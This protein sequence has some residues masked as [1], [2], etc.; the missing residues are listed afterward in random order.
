MRARVFVII[1]LLALSTAAVAQVQT[2][3]WN[4][5]FRNQ[6]TSGLLEDDLDL[7]LG[8][9]GYL[10]PARMTLIDGRRLYTNLANIFTSEEEQFGAIEAQTYVIG[11]TS[12]ILGYG[13][14]GL[15]YSQNTHKVRDSSATEDV[16]LVDIDPVTNP[17]YD[18]RYVN[19]YQDQYQ[20]T[21]GA[22]YYFLGW[23]KQVN[24]MKLGIA[25]KR[26]QNS[27]MYDYFSNS[28]ITDQNI[29]TGQTTY[30]ETIED[31]TS[32]G[33]NRNLNYV[34]ASAWKPLN[35]K[36]DVSLRLAIGFGSVKNIT[37]RD[38]SRD[39]SHSGDDSYN[40]TVDYNYDREYSG[41]A[42]SGGG[43]YVYK[44][45]DMVDTRIDM[46]YTHQGE[47][48]KSGT[49]GEYN[50]HVQ[51]IRP[52]TSSDYYD[53]GYTYA[54][55]G[56]YADNNIDFRVVHKA[57]LNR[58]VFAIGFGLY[59]GNYEDTE[60]QDQARTEVY[61]Y[62][63]LNTTTLPGSY[64]STTTW[65]EQWEYKTTGDYLYWSFP[66][67]VEF[68]LTKNIVFRLGANHQIFNS[69][70][71]ND[72]LLTGGSAVYTTV[73]RLGDGTTTITYVPTTLN[74]TPGTSD[75]HNERYSRTDYTYG[76]GWKV[77]DNLQLDFRGFAQLTDLTNWQL[78]AVF[79]F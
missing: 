76:A 19:K 31:T 66:V 47:K 43:A 57:R 20:T 48:P 62:D 46:Q 32:Q 59:T 56:E 27:D 35:D 23:A 78:S 15:L 8:S 4:N 28:E 37:E 17:G 75:T 64:V 49:T 71:T 3:P 1:A 77:T 53:Y 51:N 14:L 30:T 74:D 22:K 29:I 50:E 61:R 7:M 25:F 41:I 55:E 9:Y 73:T 10:D 44:W 65:G 26:E 33:Y 45:T 5:S 79:K 54:L 12:D 13:K 34:G 39:Y 67:C 70:I 36:M 52:A 69:D 58:A 18:T 68:D 63:S 72:T 42:L 6:S 38:Y 24:D 16:Q 2:Y 40:R 11:G 21:Q 60:T